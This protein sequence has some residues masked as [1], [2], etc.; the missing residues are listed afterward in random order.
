MVPMAGQA[1]QRGGT[2]HR[3]G[4]L[5]VLAPSP[6][7]S[8]QFL[9]D[10]LSCGTGSGDILPI[11]RGRMAALEDTPRVVVVAVRVQPEPSDAYLLSPLTNCQPNGHVQPRYVPFV[12]RLKVARELHRKGVGIH[13]PSIAAAGVFSG[14]GDYR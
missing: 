6:S 10:C 11:A 1:V 8:V 4:A 7:V 3:I 14:E 13:G 12:T 5:P 2:S 9:L